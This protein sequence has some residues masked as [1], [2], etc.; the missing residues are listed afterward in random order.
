MESISSFFLAAL[1][2]SLERIIYV[3]AWTRPEAFRRGVIR[4]RVA[5]GPV[6][7]LERL[8]YVFKGIQILVFGTWIFSYSGGV[9]ARP[10]AGAVAIATGVLLVVVGQGLNALTFYRLGRTGVFYG[11]RF[12]HTV[13]WCREFPF[14]V[15]PHP[16]Y[17][18]AVLTIWGLFVACR[19]PEPD[20]IF[21]PALETLYYLLGIH[22]ESERYATA[23]PSPP[24]E[25]APED[26]SRTQ[27]A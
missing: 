9:F 23:S 10:P 13:P 21:L 14:T 20:W 16:Q 4:L 11:A 26:S 22:F 27:A 2:L 1:L 3:L 5:A 6:T 24:R 17:L 7:A 25:R 18:G 12:G 15:T 19:S 8:F